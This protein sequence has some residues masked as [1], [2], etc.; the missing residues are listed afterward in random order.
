MRHK[1]NNI[2]HYHFAPF[3]RLP[4]SKVLSGLDNFN[5]QT[6]LHQKL[7]GNIGYLCHSASVDQDFQHGIISMVRIFGKRLTKLFSPQHG[8]V[9][10][11]QDNMVET[12]HSI[13]PYFQLPIYSLY[14][15]TR[16]PTPEMLQD[17]DHVIIDLQDVGTRIYTYIYTATLM[18][19]AC[20]EAGVQVV[21]LDRANPIGGLTIEGNM[22]DPNF[23]SFVGRH[24]LPVRHGLTIGEVAIMAKKYWGADCDLQVVPMIGWERWMSYED[25]N[26]PWVLPSP[27]LPTI[28]SAYTFVGTVL[29]EGTNISEGRGTTRSLEI[30]GH[31]DIDP[32]QVLEE[33][34]PTLA[35]GELEGFV[36]RPISF[37]PT[38]QKHQGIPCGGYQIHV[39]DRSKFRPWAL[40]QVLCKVLYHHLGDKFAW[41]QPPYEYEYEK[42]PV[43][44]INGTD[45][46]RHWVES[47]GSFEDLISIEN[48]GRADYILQ[49]ESNLLYKQ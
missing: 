37:L 49:R 3:I 30:V 21:V 25:T 24:P 35:E 48:S 17:L 43:D 16:K 40:C 38:F 14:S 29:F 5:S 20:A 2:G 28:E 32:Y 18:M 7:K 36:L 47:N 10:D 9:S 39:I 41:K 13:H 31:P 42:M 27:N 44:L 15:E 4:M 33:L 34:Q 19:E 26:L 45:Q 22:L 1:S 8:L 23:S 11:V 6:D 46:L 12:G